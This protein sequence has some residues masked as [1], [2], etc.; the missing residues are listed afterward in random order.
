[1]RQN[2]GVNRTRVGWPGRA[3]KLT[4]RDGERG[5]LDRLASAVRAGESRVLVMR[6]DPGVG[7]TV[8]Q[9][10]LARQARGCR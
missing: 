1:M 4:D 3:T 10:Y 6:G 2:G 9:D 5:V 8:L 7:K